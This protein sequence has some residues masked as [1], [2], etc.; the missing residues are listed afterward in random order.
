MNAGPRL[1]QRLHITGASGVGTSSLAQNLA[2]L[3]HCSHFDTDT[4]YWLPTSP[5]FTSRR[6]VD[7]RLARMRTDLDPNRPWIL[8][9]SLDGWGDLLIPQFDAVFFLTLDNDR[10]VERLR[11]REFE[12]YGDDVMPGGPLHDKAEAFIEWA[13]AYNKSDRPGRSL[14]RHEAW[15][16]KLPCPVIR[17]E[18]NKAPDIVTKMALK[19]IA[20][21][22]QTKQSA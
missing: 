18:N 1:V 3:L 22:N 8:S 16:A 17:L 13:S 14:K 20:N 11:Q 9:G 4:Y 21:L 19:A 5:P 6:P 2:H 12:R 15:L 7:E 10:R